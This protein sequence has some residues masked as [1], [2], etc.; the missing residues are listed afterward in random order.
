MFE[1]PSK[2][3]YFTIGVASERPIQGP[4]PC[5]H[6]KQRWAMSL[7]FRGNG[8]AC[9]AYQDQHKDQHPATP[10]VREPALTPGWLRPRRVRRHVIPP[11]AGPTS[12]PQPPGGH[13]A[14]LSR[15]VRAV[16]IGVPGDYQAE[17][18]ASS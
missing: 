17:W 12:G 6:S 10:R 16:L 2:Q 11:P 9:E 18:F 3:Q 5:L 15:A 14:D 8:F 13:R 7:P 4:T 1:T